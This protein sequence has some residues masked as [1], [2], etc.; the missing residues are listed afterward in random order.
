MPSGM[1]FVYCFGF[2]FRCHS[3]VESNRSSICR[4]Y[5]ILSQCFQIPAHQMSDPLSINYW[6]TLFTPSAP[7]FRWK[8]S[9]SLELEPYWVHFLQIETNRIIPRWESQG[10]EYLCQQR[11]TM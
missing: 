9:K 8:R 11:K 2:V 5:F 10:T 4:N 3:I 6:S 1:R 7:T